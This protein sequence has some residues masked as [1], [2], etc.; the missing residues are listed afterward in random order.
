M[1]RIVVII[2]LFA[3]FAVMIDICDTCRKVRGSYL[4]PETI[5]FSFC[6][7]SRAMRVTCLETGLSHIRVVL[8]ESDSSCNVTHTPGVNMTTW[9]HDCCTVPGGMWPISEPTLVPLMSCLLFA[10]RRLT[11]GPP[12][13]FTMLSHNCHAKSGVCGCGNRSVYW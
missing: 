11:D 6:N 13:T 7:F 5:S 2:T 4:G 1:P 3:L 10:K 9:L 12:T 8:S